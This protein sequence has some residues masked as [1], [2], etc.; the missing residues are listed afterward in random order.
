MDFKLSERYLETRIET[1]DWTSKQPCSNSQ[2]MTQ[3]TLATT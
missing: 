3:N 2:A 1:W